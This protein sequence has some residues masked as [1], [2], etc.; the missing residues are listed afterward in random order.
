[1]KINNV[2]NVMIVTPASEAPIDSAESASFKDE[3]PTWTTLIRS[4][5]VTKRGHIYL[6]HELR[7]ETM[8]KAPNIPFDKGITIFNRNLKLPQPSSTAASFNSLAKVK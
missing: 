1:M 3:I 5:F 6:F 7:K 2:G 8:A 4:V